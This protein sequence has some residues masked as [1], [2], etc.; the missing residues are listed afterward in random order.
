MKNLNERMYQKNECESMRFY[1]MPKSLFGNPI[2]KGLS[3]P[4]KSLYSILR[5]RQL[6]S[7]KNNWLDENGKVYFYFDCRELAELIE[8]STNTIIKYKKELQKYTLLF[9]KRQGQGKPNILYVLKVQS[10]GN[11]MITKK[12]DSRNANTNKQETQKSVHS[13]TVFKDTDFNDTNNNDNGATPKG[14]CTTYSQNHF[15]KNKEALQAINT[16]ML[17]FYKQKT[18]KRHPFLKPN[19]FINVYDTISSHMDEWSLCYD[20][21]VTMMLQFLNSNI[22]S[23]W[24]INHFATEGILSNRMYEVAY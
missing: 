1:Q 6:L 15:Y 8:V 18:G 13:D 16:Y 19:Q 5:D 12:Y 9:E 3:F 23:D 7:I 17:D 2:Y 21:M 20:D 22:E 4:A 11:A 14:D 10:I 24:N